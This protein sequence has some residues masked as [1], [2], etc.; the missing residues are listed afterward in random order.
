M[1]NFA[2]GWYLLYTKPRHEKKVATSLTDSSVNVYLPTAKKL[3]TWCDRKKYIDEPLFPSYVFVFLNNMHDYIDALNTEGAM[4]FVK[5]GKEIARVGQAVIDDIKLVVDKGTDIEVTAQ[6]FSAGQQLVI[7]QGPL[8]GLTCEV[9]QCN[10]REKLLVRVHLLQRNIL[11]T[12]PPADLMA[13][14]A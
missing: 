11:L 4:Y 7:S 9:V 5:F 14:S 10:G 1:K 12:L 3:R 8:T 2:I 6:Y 13:V